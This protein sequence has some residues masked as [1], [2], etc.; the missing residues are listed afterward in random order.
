MTSLAEVPL[1]PFRVQSASNRLH[2]PDG[3][4]L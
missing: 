1:T 3:S 4:V 2:G